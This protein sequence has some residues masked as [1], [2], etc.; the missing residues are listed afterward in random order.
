MHVNRLDYGVGN[1]QRLITGDFA[2]GND[3]DVVTSLEAVP[4]KATAQ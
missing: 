3:V 4:A 1:G 2:V